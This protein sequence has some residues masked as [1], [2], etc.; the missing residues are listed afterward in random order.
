MKNMFL[1]AL[2]FSSSMVYASTHK[3]SSEIVSTRNFAS[4]EGVE[5]TV[6]SLMQHA[7]KEHEVTFDKEGVRYHAFEALCAKCR[8]NEIHE[9]TTALH[10]AVKAGILGNVRILL[11][12]SANTNVVNDKKETPLHLA[13]AAER[14]DIAVLLKGAG[15]SERF[16]EHYK[17]LPRKRVQLLNVSSR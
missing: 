1:V 9:G 3:L 2:L 5:Y 11:F 10:L 6:K 4:E 8:V 13:L 15:A 7:S 12:R 17:T 16:A 14:E